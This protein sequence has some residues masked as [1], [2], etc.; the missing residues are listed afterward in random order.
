VVARFVARGMR[1]EDIEQAAL[2]DL[3]LRAVR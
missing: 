2:E 1:V 3:L